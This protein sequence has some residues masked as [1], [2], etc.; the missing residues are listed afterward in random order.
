MYLVLCMCVYMHFNANINNGNNKMCFQ[1]ILSPDANHLTW[2]AYSTPYVLCLHRCVSQSWNEQQKAHVW[3]CQRHFYYE[4]SLSLC[5][6]LQYVGICVARKST[7][8]NT[9]YL[10]L[11]TAHT[12]FKILRHG[13]ILFSSMSFDYLVMLMTNGAID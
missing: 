13:Q 3:F 5:S 2:T 1:H 8:Y 10:L 7:Q 12:H 11:N 9:E 4:Q 6:W